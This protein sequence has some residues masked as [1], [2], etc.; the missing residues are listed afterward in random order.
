MRKIITIS[1]FLFIYVLSV[2]YCD[3][4]ETIDKNKDG[5]IDTWIYRDS[6]D[7]PLKWIRDKNF[8]GKEDS[9]SFF[10]DGKAF[11]DEVDFDS[12]G[13]V[14][15]I[16]LNIYDENWKNRGFCFTLSDKEKNIFI[17]KEDTG[18]R[19]EEE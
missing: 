11:L 15:T 18:W 6:N 1:A 12:D 4:V 9:W 7:I 13:K 14:D 3:E 19:F 17:E 2:G 10:K 5:K 8:D 16:Y